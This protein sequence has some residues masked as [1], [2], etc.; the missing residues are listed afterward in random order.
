[1]LMLHVERQALL[2]INDHFTI[3]WRLKVVIL[4]SHV[5]VKG[6]AFRR[7][8]RSRVCTNPTRSE[9]SDMACISGV[10]ALSECFELW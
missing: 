7:L 2:G 8:H 3:V 9:C 4:K 6:L 1:M 5:V 10:E